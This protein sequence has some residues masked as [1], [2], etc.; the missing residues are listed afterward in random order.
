MVL[1]ARLACTLAL[2]STLSA[3]VIAPIPIDHLTYRGTATVKTDLTARVVITSS[4]KGSFNSTYLMPAGGILIP[5]AHQ[6]TGTPFPDQAVR[7]FSQSLR[8]ELVRLG[9]V[10]VALPDPDASAEMLIT[11]NIDRVDLTTDPVQYTVYMTMLIRGGTAPYRQQYRVAS[12]EKD[13]FLEKMG[14][15][16][17]Q[18]R[19][20]LALLMME[21]L[22]PDIEAYGK[23]MAP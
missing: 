4:G 7:D 5:Q 21:K 18:A 3:C 22:V 8:H 2:A 1:A 9:V 19:E 11:V 15:N 14:T 20:K 16:G 12:T 10:K 23:A 13:S 6:T 17:A